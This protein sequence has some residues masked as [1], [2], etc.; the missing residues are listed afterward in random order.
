METADVG[1]HICDGLCV[2]QMVAIRDTVHAQI[3]TPIV[4]VV[5]ELLP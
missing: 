2:R 5:D 1:G 4:S 3:P